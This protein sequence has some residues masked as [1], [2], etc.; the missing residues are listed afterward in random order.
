MPHLLVLYDTR[1]GHTALIAHTVGE[2]ARD[3]GWQADVWACRDLPSDF[4]LGSA[5]AVLV[6][7]PVIAGRFSRRL[8]RIVRH[9]R[10]DLATRPSTLLT[11]SWS[12]TESVWAP[13]TEQR[14]RAVARFFRETGW[15][16]H[17]IISVAGAILYTRHSWPARWLW[18]LFVRRSGGPHDLRRDYDFTDWEALRREVREFLGQATR[19]AVTVP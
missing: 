8:C 17:R 5:D 10:S 2:V 4:S 12:A 13:P 7:A 18:S 3:A 6:A 16:P 1:D 14:E 19:P 15:R 9:L 11:V